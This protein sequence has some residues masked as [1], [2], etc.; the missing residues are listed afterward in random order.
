MDIRHLF[1]TKWNS[2]TGEMTTQLQ[3][4]SQSQGDS[5]LHIDGSHNNVV[6]APRQSQDQAASSSSDSDDGEYG[7]QKVSREVNREL[8][9]LVIVPY[10]WSSLWHLQL[11]CRV[12]LY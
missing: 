9:K 2:L 3:T 8:E 10:R 5:N 12:I 7:K 11:C 4:Q 6:I 1:Q